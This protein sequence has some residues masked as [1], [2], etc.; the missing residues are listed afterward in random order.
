MVT[1]AHGPVLAA[2]LAASIAVPSLAAASPNCDAFVVD[3]TNRPAD[4]AEFAR[5]LA[6]MANSAEEAGCLAD[7]DRLLEGAHRIDP[8]PRLVYERILV[9]EKMLDFAYA[10]ALLEAYRPELAAENT[11]TDL[12]ELDARLRAKM[13]DHETPIEPL[14]EPVPSR[15]STLDTVG[16]ILLAG[17]GAGALGMAVYGFTASCQDVASDGV[18][19]QGSETRFGPTVG[20]AAT[21]V[22]ALTGA[23]IW[24]VIAAPPLS[25]ETTA[26]V[27]IAPAAITVR[28]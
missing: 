27:S 15:R 18:C 3:D 1:T 11:I 5:A 14:R 16:P 24:W 13:R 8:E 9:R 20:F 26:H 28:F 12:V 6:G 23:A 25:R 22:A 19:L 21:G 7:A 2:L 17:I 10:H 4:N